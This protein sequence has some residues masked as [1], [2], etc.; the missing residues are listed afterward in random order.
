[1]NTR[2]P[3]IAVSLALLA[4]CDVF[5]P[6]ACTTE[7]RPGFQIFAV[8]E[9]GVTPVID[10]LRVFVRDGD[11]VEEL[12]GTENV[13]HGTW[14]RAGVYRVD[15]GAT[16]YRPWVRHNVRVIQDECHVRTVELTAQM[17]PL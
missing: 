2:R 16:G 14:E 1:V 11:Y 10:G 13:R 6:D 4:S 7:S 8:S 3:L 12:M 17:A 15:V 5:G 9:S